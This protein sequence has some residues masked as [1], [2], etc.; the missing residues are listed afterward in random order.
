[1]DQ[2]TIERVMWATGY[3][4]GYL[5]SRGI[6]VRSTYDETRRGNDE[7]LVLTLDDAERRTVVTLRVIDVT[8]RGMYPA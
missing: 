1:M 3:T 8:T 4:Q 6:D 5:A 2:A 7:C